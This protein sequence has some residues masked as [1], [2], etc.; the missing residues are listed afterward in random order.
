M[1]VAVN[2]GDSLTVNITIGAGCGGNSLAV[3]IGVGA[4]FGGG[5]LTANIG[6][7]SRH[8]AASRLTRRHLRAAA[9]AP[10]VYSFFSIKYSRLLFFL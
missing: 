10:F 2:T 1:V 5:S 8:A 4:G 9:V 7:E 3:D 6:T